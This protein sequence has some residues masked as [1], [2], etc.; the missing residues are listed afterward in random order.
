MDTR[1]KLFVFY[2]QTSELDLPQY[3]QE[4]TA[5]YSNR[6]IEL[7]RT[8]INRQHKNIFF[9]TSNAEDLD[10]VVSNMGKYTKNLHIVLIT[11]DE[12][13]LDY[14]FPKFIHPILTKWLYLSTIFTNA[15]REVLDVLDKVGFDR[16]PFTY[17]AKENISDLMHYGGNDFLKFI[18]KFRNE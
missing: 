7:D 8:H 18:E 10:I 15:Y 3:F 16:D 13:I 5:K 11:D 4:L 17:Y 14:K 12:K 1:D 9:I 6:I 2:D